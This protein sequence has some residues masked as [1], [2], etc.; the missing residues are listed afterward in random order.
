MF[1]LQV[2]FFKPLWIRLVT[3]ALPL[4]WAV[5]ELVSGSPGWALIFGAAGL[6]AAWQFFVVWTPKDNERKDD[7]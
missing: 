7:G 4:G 2:P 1:N 3:T 5:V 6:Y